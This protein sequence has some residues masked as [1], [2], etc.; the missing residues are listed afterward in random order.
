MAVAMDEQVVVV[1]SSSGGDVV[2]L[3]FVFRHTRR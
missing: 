3:A 2:E 1:F